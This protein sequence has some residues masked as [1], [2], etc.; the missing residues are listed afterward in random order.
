MPESEAVEMSSDR[1]SIDGMAAAIMEGLE[2][3]AEL[4]TA[5]MKKAV[6][7]AGSNI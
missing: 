4:A 6:R 2:E 7:K 5:D 3:Y 1:V